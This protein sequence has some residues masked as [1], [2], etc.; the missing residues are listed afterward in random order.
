VSHIFGS[1]AKIAYLYWRR[2]EFTLDRDWLRD[3]AYPMLRGAVEFYR[4]HP[5]LKKGEDGRYHLYWANSNESVYGA[6]DTDEDVS[7]M[8]GT[9]AALVRAAEI[10][11]AEPSMLP[12]WREF[13]DNLPPL[14]LSDNPEALKPANYAGPRVFVRGL[15][16]AVKPAGL[17]P[18]SNSLPMWFF[19][20]CN[21]ESADRQTLEIAGTTLDQAFRNGVKEDT[22]VSV[23]SKLA[24]AAASLGRADAVRFLIP[25]QMRALRPERSAAYK[26]GG[27]LANRMTLREGQQA[28]DAQRL[29]RASEA[30]HMALLQSNPPAPG[31]GPI[32]HLFPACPKEWDVRFTL[33][34]RGAFIVSAARRN[35][36]VAPV[37]IL[38]QAGAPCVLRNPFGGAATLYRDGR[39]AE[40]LNGGLLRFPT[41]KGEKIVVQAV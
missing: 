30:L 15:K 37:E 23:L 2:Y 16:P 12:V 31:Q 32:L 17:L 24:I 4:N 11:N 26:S 40:T 22:P 5:N 9:S 25:N 29:G 34:A 41:R 38:S 20:F 6:R 27:V 3:R 8:R 35:G 28:L 33:L 7:S 19:D 1:T 10:L 18:D 14:P 13:R 39:K 21:V 36:T